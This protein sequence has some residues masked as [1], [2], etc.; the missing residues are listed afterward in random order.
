[1]SKVL[2]TTTLTAALFTL[3]IGTLLLQAIF[4]SP[5]RQIPLE[6]LPEQECDGEA[7]P[8]EYPF[9]GGFI[10]PHACNV[11]CADQIQRYILYSNGL[12]TPCEKLPGCL[13][14]GEDRGITCRPPEPLSKVESSNG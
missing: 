3:V 11:Q 5:S 8:V 2:H 1:M 6:R 9:Q 14:W 7:L 12:A 4:R 13:D 10:E